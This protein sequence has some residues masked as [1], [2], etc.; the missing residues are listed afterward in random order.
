MQREPF[1]DTCLLELQGWGYNL[2]KELRLETSDE[3]NYVP[4]VYTLHMVYHTALIVLGN[5]LLSVKPGT[6]VVLS[7]QTRQ[8][9]LKT[10]HEAA[11]NVC[12][13]ARKYRAIFGSFRRSP[14]S[15]THCLH[16]AALVFIQIEKARKWHPSIR[17]VTESANLCLNALTELSFAWSPA[18]RIVQNLIF[19]R[20]QQDH[21][22][23]KST[24]Q[25]P[26][27]EQDV[28]SSAVMPS[29]S[30][31][32]PNGSDGVRPSGQVALEGL[33]PLLTYEHGQLSFDLETQ[34]PL[35]FGFGVDLFS[36]GLMESSAF[37]DV[38][39]GFA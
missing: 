39:L 18:K 13:V 27:E 8:K 19:T 35:N 37:M 12:M 36:D 10:C 22:S 34:D 21:V 17:T 7:H 14:L 2:S 23:L 3:K 6:T 5:A 28:A 29:D 25:D 16:S 4:Q 30:A 24:P 33:E 1:F 15:A 31:S 11:R 26:V 32:G 38:D 9:A 20:S